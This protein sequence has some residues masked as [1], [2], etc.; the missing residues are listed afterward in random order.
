[1]VLLSSNPKFSGFLCPDFSL[2]S[3]DDKEFSLND[4]KGGALLVAFICNHCPY[5]KAIEDRL[6]ELRRKFSESELSMVAICSNDAERYPDDSKASLLKRWQEK[7][8]GFPYLVDVDQNVAKSFDAVC[9]PDLFLF[10]QQRKLFYHGA[11]DDSPKDPQKVS[12]QY[13]KEAIVGVLNKE[14]APLDQKPSMGC[15]IKW[16]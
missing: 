13:L 7:D 15:S 2:Q 12:R 5:V 3:V 1:M 14:P 9:T 10:D 8:Y 16:K 6:L 4:A 11:L